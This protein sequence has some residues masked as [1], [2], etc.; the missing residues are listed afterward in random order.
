MRLLLLALLPLSCL[1]NPHEQEIQRA[2]IERDRQSA[3][4][5]RGVPAQPLPADAGRPLHADPVI[6]RELRPY[7]RI[8]DAQAHELRFAPPVV[9][10][11]KSGSDPD[12][13]SQPLPLPG[14]PRH[15]VEP[16]A[17]TGIRG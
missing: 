14:G 9:L 7:E 17:P 16:V 2:L 8:R 12:F 15:G 1:A 6:A 13:G 5:A 11:K 3:D 10:R 4:F